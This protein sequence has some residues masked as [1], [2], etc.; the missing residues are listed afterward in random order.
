MT[1]HEAPG[2]NAG[3][4]HDILRPARVRDG[5]SDPEVRLTITKK[6][7]FHDGGFVYPGQAAFAD[8]AREFFLRRL[9]EV[10]FHSGTTISEIIEFLRV[11][12][13]PMKELFESGGFESRLWDAGVVNVTVREAS[14][15]LVE[16]DG[17]PREAEEGW[18]PEPETI[19]AKL[20]EA[21]AGRLRD[22][23]VLVRLVESPE[24]FGAY[25]RDEPGERAGERARHPGSR[26]TH[27]TPACHRRGPH[28]PRRGDAP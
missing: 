13:V 24:A 26:R 6:G 25:L 16:A 14:V 10:R 11:L 4:G 12:D 2:G 1:V 20:A 22:Q 18:P 28:A 3:S 23:V 17:I 7:L 15:R 5:W 27:G 8:F 9:A 21:S 19:E